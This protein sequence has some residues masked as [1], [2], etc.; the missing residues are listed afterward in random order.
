V[1]RIWWNYEVFGAAIDAPS[2]FARNAIA[3]MGKI[4]CFGDLR[5]IAQLTAAVLFAAEA[6]A[7]SCSLGDSKEIDVDLFLFFCGRLA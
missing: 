3:K 1:A 4:E 7:A 6:I 5:E 2:P